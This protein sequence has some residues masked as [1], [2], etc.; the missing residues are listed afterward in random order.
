MDELLNGGY[1]ANKVIGR[2]TQHFIDNLDVAAIKRKA[3]LH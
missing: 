2:F 1:G 3:G